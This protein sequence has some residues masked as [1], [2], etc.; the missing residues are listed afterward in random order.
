MVDTNHMDPILF[1]LAAAARNDSRST[2]ENACR[3][4]AQCLRLI[5]PVIIHRVANM[6]REI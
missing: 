5:P 6:Y 1:E 4:T 3:T 2:L